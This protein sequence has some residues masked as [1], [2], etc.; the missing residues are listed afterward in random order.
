MY[1]WSEIDKLAKLLVEY[2]VEVVKE[3]TKKG[4][5]IEYTL[6]SDEIKE[7]QS[8]Y[9]NEDQLKSGNMMYETILCGTQ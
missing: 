2:S 8:K 4:A 7:I 1:G 6:E 9:G 5:H 3:A